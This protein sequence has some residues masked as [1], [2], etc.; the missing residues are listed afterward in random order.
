M[1]LVDTHN[2]EV[3][4]IKAIKSSSGY[5]VMNTADAGEMTK[6]AGDTSVH[7]IK[8]G[9]GILLRLW[10]PNSLAA[11]ATL[12]IDSTDITIP[13][14][15]SGVIELKIVFHSNIKVQ[16]GNTGDVIVSIYV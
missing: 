16:L 4:N 13:S 12:S 7:T 5:G 1:R 6:T 2:N 8:S 11:N 14:G 10:I 15:T 9:D 3:V